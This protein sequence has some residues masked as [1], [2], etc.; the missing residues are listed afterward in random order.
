MM[1]IA[2]TGS[3]WRHLPDEYGK[4]NS[5]FRRYRRWVSTGVF[6]AMLETL[7]E[8]VER[9]VT[10]DMI[11]ST[12]VRAHHCAV[13]IKGDSGNRGSWSIA[14]WLQHKAP[15]PM[16][17]KRAPSRVCPDAWAKSRHTGLRPAVPHDRRQD[18][19][20]A[21]RQGYDADAIREELTKADV[22]AVIPA[23]SNRREPIAHDREKY[24]WRNLVERLFNKLKNWRRIATRYDKTKES[25]LGFVNL[26]S[27]LQWIP[28]VHEA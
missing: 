23:K 18:R 20:A 26:V 13:G 27:V 28:F 17:R 11:D 24:R 8:M 25:Y 14:R 19:G 3:Q 21:G 1:W 12:V 7:T 2:R 16:R 10:A 6:D 15:R 4:W 5:V 9:D 22:E